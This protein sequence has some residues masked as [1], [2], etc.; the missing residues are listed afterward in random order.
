MPSSLTTLPDPL[1]TER[2]SRFVQWRTV[3]WDDPINLMDYV[4]YV[5]RRHFGYPLTTCES[6]MLQVHEQGRA[7]VSTGTR[8]RMEA[9]VA[10]MH[11]YG[12]HATLEED[13]GS[14]SSERT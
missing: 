4:T 13:D 1:V 8:E 5:F 12:L 6:L 7:I 3:V 9:D 14:E 11:G 10:A 2:S